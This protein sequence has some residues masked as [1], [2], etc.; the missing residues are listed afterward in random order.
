MHNRKYKLF[1]KF[2]YKT[3]SLGFWYNIE[4]NSNWKNADTISLKS[5]KWNAAESSVVWKYK[6]CD[7]SG[8]STSSEE[9][10]WPVLLQSCCR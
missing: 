9:V 1:S 3:W 10:L 6:V 8:T 5:W 4:Y 2:M 7:C